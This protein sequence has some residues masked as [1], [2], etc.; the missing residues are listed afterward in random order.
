[1]VKSSLSHFFSF[2]YFLGAFDTKVYL[3]SGNQQN[4][5]FFIPNMS[6]SIKNVLLLERPF[7]K[8][9]DSNPF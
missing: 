6:F 5:Q 4:Y 8:I 1:M 3:N 9:S 7:F 2:N